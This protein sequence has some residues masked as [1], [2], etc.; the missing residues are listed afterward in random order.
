MPRKREKEPKLTQTPITLEDIP[1]IGPATAKKLRKAGFYTVY[2]IAAAPARELADTGGLSEDR[3]REISVEARSLLNLTFH[4]GRD[5]YEYRKHLVPLTTG[6]PSL[7]DLLDGGI[8][9]KFV[10]EL[11]GQFASGKTQI[12]HA[13][14]VFVQNPYHL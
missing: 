2:A 13:A 8:H 12:C 10:I 1:K 9:P 7:D 5:L 6:C 4:T 11:I 14:C 3:A